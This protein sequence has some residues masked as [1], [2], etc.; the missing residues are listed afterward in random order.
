MTISNSISKDNSSSCLT[1]DT[2]VSSFTSNGVFS[3]TQVL[4][5]QTDNEFK[6]VDIQ[7]GLSSKVYEK[8]HSFSVRNTLSSR[9]SD[10][11][12]SYLEANQFNVVNSK[13]PLVVCVT[14]GAS[15]SFK[16]IEPAS[17]RSSFLSYDIKPKIVNIRQ[18]NTSNLMSQADVL[19]RQNFSTNF[20]H[21]HTTSDNNISKY[22]FVLCGC[23]I[24][25]NSKAYFFV[26]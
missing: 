9:S 7:P 17:T 20:S 15:T 25:T 13:Q 2:S 19:T 22:V 16:P 1:N 18:N 23:V 11:F 3:Y 4:E 21:N 12:S 10:S 24:I 6:T 14:D 8:R 26:D 5:D